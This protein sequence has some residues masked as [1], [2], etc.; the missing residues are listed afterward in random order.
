MEYSIDD[1]ELH[2]VYI[3][4]DIVDM[5]YL[6]DRIALDFVDTEQD[7][8]Y[9]AY[10]I[11]DSKLDFVYIEQDFVQA[12]WLADQAAMDIAYYCG[13]FSEPATIMNTR[14]HYSRNAGYTYS[15]PLQLIWLQLQLL[16]ALYNDFSLPLQRFGRKPDAIISSRL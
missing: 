5:E 10:S 12:T 16:Q 13:R 4:L 9:M 8:V 15:P 11:D 1:H 6:S 2:F 3:D 14:S 7:F